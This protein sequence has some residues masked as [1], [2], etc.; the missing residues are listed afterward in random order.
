[1]RNILLITDN[2]ILEEVDGK[3]FHRCLDDH[4][5]AYGTLGNLTLCV[6]IRHTVSINR[7]IDL[8]NIR[9]VEINKENNIY[10]RFID[11]R[12][13]KRIIYDEVKNAD[14]IVG[15]VPSSVCDLAATYARKFNKI[16]LS[17]VIASAWDILWH[18]SLKG[19]LMAPFSHFSTKRTILES[20]YAIYVTERYLQNKYPTKGISTSISDVVIK[21]LD[22]QTLNDRVEMILSRKDIKKLSLLSVG[23]INIKYK[24]QDEVIK[25]MAYLANE[26]YDI[27]YYLIGGG[28]KTRLHAIAK[29]LGIADKVHFIGGLPHEEVFQ[30]FKAIDIYIQPSRTEGLPRAV[31]EAMSCAAPIIC[32]NIGGMPELV[33]NDCLYKSGDIND[34]CMKI[35]ELSKSPDNLI[36]KAKYNFFKAETFQTGRLNTRREAFIRSIH[37]NRL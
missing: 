19:K 32:S 21:Y 3:F 36:R 4:I 6:P 34:L 17:V 26:G 13:N 22:K 27:D 24:G 9:I 18:H 20:D 10:K 29:G 30:Y 25:A 8:T 31:V 1:M 28:D 35:K 14:I 12:E 23:A 37:D 7:P 16:F 15:F 33:E 2:Y 11:R 5:S